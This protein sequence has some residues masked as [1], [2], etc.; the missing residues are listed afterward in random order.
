MIANRTLVEY[1]LWQAMDEFKN[2]IKNLAL[3]E[4]DNY[5]DF[6][7]IVKKHLGFIPTR[8]NKEIYQE[9]KD[10]KKIADKAL[11]ISS[12]LATAYRKEGRVTIAKLEVEY[13]SII[14]SL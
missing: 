8:K 11:D 1:E 5:S 14:E 12:E 6:D 13:Y 3:D 9:Y 10:Y 7:E 2:A 4:R